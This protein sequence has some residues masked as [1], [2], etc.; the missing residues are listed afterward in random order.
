V[1]H[2]IYASLSHTEV[3]RNGAALAESGPFAIG[4]ASWGTFCEIQSC[5]YVSVSAITALKRELGTNWEG[6]SSGA[7]SLF[8]ITLKTPL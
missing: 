3:T 8:W 2:R 6:C 7:L 4:G 5:P 1:R